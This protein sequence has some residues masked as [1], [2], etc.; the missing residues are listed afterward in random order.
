MEYL[1]FENISMLLAI[2]G[3]IVALTPTEKDDA[4]FDRIKNV[5]GKFR[6]EK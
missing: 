3:W 2:I 5:I 1:T 4:I 6:R